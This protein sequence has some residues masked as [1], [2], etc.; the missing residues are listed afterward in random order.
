MQHVIVM[1]A[2]NLARALVK[3]WL[4]QTPLGMKLSILTRSNAYQERGW[5]V[6]DRAIPTYDPEILTT[7]DI[8]V[9]AVKPKDVGAALTTVHTYAPAEA[10]LLSCVAGVTLR[11]LTGA[12]PQRSIVRSMPNI[13]VAV[14]DGTVVVA[15]G[16]GLEHALW[17]ILKSYLACLGHVAV[18]SEVWLDPA[19][20]VS[21]SGP[22]YAYVLLQALLEAGS[23][24]G[25]PDSLARELAAHALRGAAELALAFPERTFSEL[26]RWV[27]S[28]GGTTEA[29]LAVLK[30][31]E[32]EDTLRRAIVAAGSQAARL[33]QTGP[34][35]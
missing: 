1:G 33:G 15:D 31:T 34:Q 14:H 16:N 19:T 22:A 7:A 9:L 10:L 23:Q 29:A 13:A 8:I 27:A 25:L 6:D 26:T 17:P 2:G 5:V 28:P 21:G 24:M 30:R 35:A 12:L 4:D 20:A 32:V 18:V 3:G 11:T